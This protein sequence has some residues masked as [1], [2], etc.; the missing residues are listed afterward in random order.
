MF[1]SFSGCFRNWFGKCCWRCFDCSCPCRAQVSTERRG[2]CSLAKRC[3]C[4]RCIH[5]ISSWCQPGLNSN[6]EDAGSCCWWRSSYC[7][8][9][10]RTSAYVIDWSLRLNCPIPQI[11]VFHC[12][13]L[14]LLSGVLQDD[15]GDCFLLCPFQVS[16]RYLAYL[17]AIMSF[18]Y[19]LAVKHFYSGPF[20]HLSSHS[21]PPSCSHSN[22]SLKMMSSI[23]A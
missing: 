18:A 17:W 15:F 16:C 9:W 8:C 20:R 2:S 3:Y 10:I 6:I 4:C 21:N 13:F 19:R 1:D 11:F 23:G 14:G 7:C 12:S 22:L 5:L